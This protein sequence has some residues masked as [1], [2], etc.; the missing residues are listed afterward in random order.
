[1]PE[2]GRERIRF[3]GDREAVDE[4]ELAVADRGNGGI[5]DLSNDFTGGRKSL[6]PHSSAGIVEYYLQLT[7]PIS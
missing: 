2:W 6:V 7:N 4:A 3:T 1:M 5:H